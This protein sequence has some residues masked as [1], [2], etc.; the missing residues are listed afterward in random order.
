M[1]LV[2][3]EKC[4]VHDSEQSQKL[5][6]ICRGMCQFDWDSPLFAHLSYNLTSLTYFYS[7]QLPQ[8]MSED[9]IW[10][11]CQVAQPLKRRQNLITFFTKC[12]ES[13]FYSRFI[14]G[15][16]LCV[17]HSPQEEFITSSLSSAHQFLVKLE[18]WLER[19]NTP[20][21]LVEVFNHFSRTTI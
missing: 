4:S 12:T 1:F 17:K 8:L 11:T 20:M 15:V 9:Q 13:L 5:S 18:G 14:Q 6:T 2:C 3:I 7:P 21:C 19:L 16:A 10:V